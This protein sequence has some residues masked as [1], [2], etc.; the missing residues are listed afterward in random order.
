[1]SKVLKTGKAVENTKPE[2]APV[3]LTPVQKPDNQR[4]YRIKRGVSVAFVNNVVH[5]AADN[6]RF[7]E[8]QEV[9]RLVKDGYL[10]LDV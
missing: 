8:N 2:A 4:F 3:A 10:E 7:A 1:M 6:P 9:V 5:S